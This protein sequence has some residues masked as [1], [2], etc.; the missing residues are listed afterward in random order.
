MISLEKDI[1]KFMSIMRVKSKDVDITDK[2]SNIQGQY[3]INKIKETEFGKISV[4]VQNIDDFIEMK[5]FCQN[6]EFLPSVKLNDLGE[7]ENISVESIEVSEIKVFIHKNTSEYIFIFSN[8]AHI[9]K[10][11][12]IVEIVLEDL[13]IS[14]IIFN[15][16]MFEYFR[17]ISN[18]YSIQSMTF[19]ESNNLITLAKSSEKGI[20]KDLEFGKIKEI[21]LE[22]HLKNKIKMKIND[23]GLITL[24]NRPGYVDILILIELF[25][26]ILDETDY[27][28]RYDNE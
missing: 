12:K 2:I 13:E 10:A 22:I 28:R 17:N 23:K 8:K 4:K 6:I 5:I 24:F 15:N 26:K 18:I 25:I 7:I 19:Q 20:I 16:E 3:L 11:Q 9:L 14:R 1:F 21:K 27:Y